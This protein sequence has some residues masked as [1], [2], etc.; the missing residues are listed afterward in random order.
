MGREAPMPTEPPSQP[1]TMVSKPATN[2]LA[3]CIYVCSCL[4][5]KPEAGICMCVIT[6]SSFGHVQLCM[7]VHQGG[8]AHSS[9]A[10]VRT[11]ACRHVSFDNSGLF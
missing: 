4:R 2:P 6:H 1:S 11:V 7:V 9:I 5:Q 3:T 8:G 10:D